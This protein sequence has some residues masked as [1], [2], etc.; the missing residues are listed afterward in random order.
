MEQG[1]GLGMVVRSLVFGLAFYG[2]TLILSVLLAPSML[3]PRPMVSAV[4][5]FWVRVCLWVVKATLGIDFKVEGRENMPDGPAIY[6]SKHQSAAETLAFCLVVP[7]LAYILK[8]ELFWVP[9][10]GW[11]V[12]CVGMIG[13]NRAAGAAALKD[14]TRKATQVLSAGR[15]I[16]IFPQGTRTAPGTHRKYL[17]GA[18]ALY[19]KAG[20]PVV[21]VALN[22]GLFWPRR[23]L[24]KYRGTFTIRIMEPIPPGL[25]K[26]AFLQRLEQTIEPATTELEHRACEE[27]GLHLPAPAAE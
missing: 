9:I 15:S 26:R 18:A 10:W 13:V 1:R 19:A 27:F 21:P 4:S 20:V 3:L 11:Y 7:D 5:R 2:T 24:A 16:V 12:W 6:A 8:R 23:K 22:S 25:D 14:M 17:P